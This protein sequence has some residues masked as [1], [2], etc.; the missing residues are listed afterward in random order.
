M[1]SYGQEQKF[2]RLFFAVLG[3]LLWLFVFPTTCSNFITVV[4]KT[5]RLDVCETLKTQ[6]KIL[7]VEQKSYRSSGN[8]IMLIKYQFTAQET[9][10]EGRSEVYLD[11]VPDGET[12]EVRY[13]EN[14]PEINAFVDENLVMALMKRLVFLGLLSGLAYWIVSKLLEVRKYRNDL[15]SLPNLFPSRR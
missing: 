3:T 7:E 11:R 1:L 12:L 9:I 8:H 14:K 5:I 2:L 13:A 4:E 10:F 6:G 15:E